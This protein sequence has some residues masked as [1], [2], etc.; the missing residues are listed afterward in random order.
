[1][2]R[3]FRQQHLRKAVSNITVIEP[4]KS[5]ESTKRSVGSTGGAYCT[6]AKAFFAFLKVTHRVLDHLKK[7]DHLKKA[8]IRAISSTLGPL[9]TIQLIFL[10]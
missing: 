5:V 10:G 4:K 9:T 3:V 6:E 2:A 7:V 8:N 1:M